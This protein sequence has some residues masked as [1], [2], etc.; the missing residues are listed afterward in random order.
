[1]KKRISD[2]KLCILS[3][4]KS[5]DLYYLSPEEFDNLVSDLKDAREELKKYAKKQSL[6]QHLHTLAN[7]HKIG[8]CVSKT[9]ISYF[10]RGYSA[11][12]AE[13]FFYFDRCCFIDD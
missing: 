7:K 2:E 12:N 10:N 1:M 4:R 8:F 13:A 11:P 6:S 5:R 3:N 9:D